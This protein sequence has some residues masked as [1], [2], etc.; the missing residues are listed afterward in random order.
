LSL[1]TFK[2]AGIY[3]E[4]ADVYIDPWRKVD[5][6]LITHGHADHSRK[7]NGHYLTTNQ[8]VPILKHRLGKIK[9]DGLD[10]GEEIMINGVK[11]SFHPAGHIIGSAQIRV[12]HKGEIWV[13][14][15]DYKTV[16]D[17]VSGV[18]EAVKCHHFITESTFGLPVYNWAPQ[19]E[20]I[21][22]INQW[23]QDNRS[24]GISSIISA[25]SLGKA[26]RLLFNLDASI[27]PIYTHNAVENIN[28]I[29]RANGISLPETIRIS[30]TLK[31][32]DL[33]GA[34]VISPGPAE[35][36]PWTKLFKPFKTA[37][38]S[39]WMMLRGM[40][41][42]RAIDKGFVLSDHADWNGLN[43]AVKATGAENIYVTHGSTEVFTQWLNEAGYNAQVLKT[44]FLG[45]ETE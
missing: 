37:S 31:K 35:G 13:C 25:Y 38:A 45:E 10:Y 21:A 27:G 12:E 30:D 34:L 41:R 23:W 39:G 22:D 40:R 29:F 15:G 32:A 4:K 11:L 44:E 2:K 6:A 20:V 26:Q 19:Q 28:E 18:F 3:C 36:A 17:G 8:S 1:I 9:I 14:S 42:R 5:K 16:N 24:N 33:K 7:G 43:E